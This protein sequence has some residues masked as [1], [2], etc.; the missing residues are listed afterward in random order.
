MYIEFDI[1]ICGLVGSLFYKKSIT[2]T[3][4][5]KKINKRVSSDGDDIESVCRLNPL[6]CFC[7]F[8]FP[9]KSRTITNMS[10]KILD[11]IDNLS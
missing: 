6:L 7:V 1:D 4:T 2:I 5:I 10:F 9:R 3:D 11:N 8:Y